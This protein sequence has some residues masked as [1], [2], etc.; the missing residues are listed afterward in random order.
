VFAIILSTLYHSLLSTLSELSLSL[1][2][3]STEKEERL[4]E[5]DDEQDQFSS[6]HASLLLLIVQQV[7]N[8]LLR[9]ACKNNVYDVNV[10]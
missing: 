2:R 10:L 8:D 6:F 4:K 3:E 7:K 1:A 9:V 5:R